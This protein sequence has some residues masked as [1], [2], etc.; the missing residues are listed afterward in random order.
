MFVGC[1]VNL[2]TQTPCNYR[3]YY[4][5]TY[6][7]KD[8]KIKNY[9]KPETHLLYNTG[10]ESRYLAKA[11]YW[12][13]STAIVTKNTGVTRT[14]D[15]KTGQVTSRVSSAN[16][17]FV[18]FDKKVTKNINRGETSIYLFSLSDGV[19]KFDQKHNF[20]W[21]LQD[22]KDTIMGI[23][24]FM[25]NCWYGGR[26]YTAWFAP[27]I[28]IFDGPYVFHGIPGLILKLYDKMKNFIWT[29]DS[30]ETSK[31]EVVHK[32]SYWFRSPLKPT[33]EEFVKICNKVVNGSANSEYVQF[34]PEDLT[35]IRERNRKKQYLLIEQLEK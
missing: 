12:N 35:K 33:R 18:N 30:F 19:C 16:K 14:I 1:F 3:V 15:P 2:H 27:S 10:E 20:N 4:K 21:S 22:Q 11:E 13:D 8:S 32:D 31:S 25:A 24:V 7:Q 26:E 28:P 34:T 23:E 9:Y 5:F 6:D 29:I 17:K